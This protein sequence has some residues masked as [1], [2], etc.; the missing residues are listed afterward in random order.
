MTP[1]TVSLLPFRSGAMACSL[2]LLRAAARNLA[3]AAAVALA[4]EPR[5]L[6]LVALSS[7]L[8]AAAVAIAT[9]VAEA[10]M[11]GHLGKLLPWDLRRA[12]TPV[13]AVVVVS[14]RAAL[15]VPLGMKVITP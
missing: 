7:L 14:L 8:P 1:A 4:A 12:A 10:V 13:A 9:K 11:R 2:L 3:Y 5:P 15:Q 6:H